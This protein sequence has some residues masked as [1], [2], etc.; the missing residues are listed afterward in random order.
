MNNLPKDLPKDPTPG[1]PPDA[2]GTLDKKR[3]FEDEVHA[4]DAKLKSYL[5]G[6][7]PTVDVEDVV[8]E[9]YLRTW[10]AS[11][12]KP[13]TSA[14]AFLFTVARR[15]AIDLLRAQ[16]KS[17][18][19]AVS[20]L[21]V[22]DVIDDGRDP[23]EAAAVN[24][25]IALL[26]DAIDTLPPNCREIILLRKLRGMPQSEVAA[27]FSSSEAAVGQQV[28]RGILRLQAFFIE[29]GTI[30]PWQNTSR[31]QIPKSKVPKSKV[32]KS[33]IPKSKVPKSKVQKPK[34][35]KSK[36][37]YSKSTY[38]KFTKSKFTKSKTTNSKSLPK[39]Q[40]RSRKKPKS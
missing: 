35:Q 3:W 13:V 34:A 23:A 40:K 6:L 22:L 36:S 26:A 1:T 14:K 9:S 7:F 25:E 31:G 33:K 39:S 18:I 5:R 37:T 38:S 11:A 15:L 17:P 30:K 24:D 27:L 4:H 29:R 8:Q 2:P 28:C 32:Q 20:N 12:V 16:K 21:T 10:I 19:T